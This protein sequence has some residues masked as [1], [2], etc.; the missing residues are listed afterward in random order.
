MP[1]EI[2]YW[3]LKTE[4]K[5][6][7][8]IIIF[9]NL[10]IEI[11][12]LLGNKLWAEHQTKALN[13][14]LPHRQCWGKWM[15]P[16][17]LWVFCFNNI[18]STNTILNLFLKKP[19]KSCEIQQCRM[20]CT[21]TKNCKQIDPR[22]SQW[23]KNKWVTVFQT[24]FSLKTQNKRKNSVRRLLYSLL[25]LTFFVYVYICTHMYVFLLH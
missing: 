13:Q 8:T 20:Y 9:T 10:C 22:G 24:I 17:K 15:I 25:Y 7:E 16:L 14:I 11:W 21:L 19:T 2:Q 6:L 5:W 1:L 23:H 3:T 4:L 18:I 12:L